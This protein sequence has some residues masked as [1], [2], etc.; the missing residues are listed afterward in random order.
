MSECF[1]LQLTYFFNVV[2]EEYYNNNSLTNKECIPWLI[3]SLKLVS[4]EWLDKNCRKVWKIAVIMISYYKIVPINY[5]GCKKKMHKHMQWAMAVYIIACLHY[6]QRQITSF[7]ITNLQ[8]LAILQRAASNEPQHSHTLCRFNESQ[9]DFKIAILSCKYHST[10]KVQKAKP[11]CCCWMMLLT[12]Q[13]RWIS[14]Y[15]VQVAC[16][17][18]V[19]FPTGRMLLCNFFQQNSS[20]VIKDI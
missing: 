1:K 17:E 6:L 16:M 20:K 15:E 7:L 14:K 4:T 3:A 19:W 13:V 18:S 9:R 10:V 5:I 11:L 8:H 12:A 2:L